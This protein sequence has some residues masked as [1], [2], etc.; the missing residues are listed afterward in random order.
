ML[1]RKFYSFVMLEFC[2]WYR[3]SNQ[4]VF[5]FKVKDIYGGAYDALKLPGDLTAS[6]FGKTVRSPRDDQHTGL[7]KS[8][9]N[10]LFT[11][12]KWNA[13]LIVW[14]IFLPVC[15]FH[16]VMGCSQSDWIF[17]RP[18]RNR[19]KLMITW[20][21]CLFPPLTSGAHFSALGTA[22]MLLLWVLIGSLL[23]LVFSVIGQIWTLWFW[24]W[25]AKTKSRARARL[26][27][28]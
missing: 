7:W 2:N 18:V 12:Y 6:S 5:Y 13:V 22:C 8:T 4:R 10:F 26:A 27:Q 9:S 3:E 21:V 24:Q 11:C 28:P 16:R 17:F 20:L 23:Y 14:R 25:R 1:V 15:P 19:T